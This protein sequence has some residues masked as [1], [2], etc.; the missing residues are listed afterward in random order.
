MI[1]CNA[2]RYS[3][4]AISEKYHES[5]IRHSVMRYVIFVNNRFMVN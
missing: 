4:A 5:N 2:D 1:V 3:F